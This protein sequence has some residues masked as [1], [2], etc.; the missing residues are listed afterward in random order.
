LARPR[1][2]ELSHRA[3]KALEAVETRFRDRLKDA[4]RELANNP[5]AGKKLK[6]ELAGLR[7][8]RLGPFR[9]VYRFMRARVEVVFI[10]DRKDVYR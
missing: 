8:Y 4:I 3:E 1:G 10:D 2:V 5:L 7:S 6:G 9:I